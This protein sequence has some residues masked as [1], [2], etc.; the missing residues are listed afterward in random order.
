[1]TDETE[2]QRLERLREHYDDTDTSAEM[3]QGEWVDP[4]TGDAA[5]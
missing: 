3:E 5:P 2:Q 4:T 1:M